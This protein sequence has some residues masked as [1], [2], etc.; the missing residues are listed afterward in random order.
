MLFR[1]RLEEAIK[2]DPVNEP[3]YFYLRLVM[4]SQF[5]IESKKREKTYGDRVVQ[6]TKK[7]NEGTRTD[8]PMPNQ[9]FRTNSNRPFLTH[10][11]LGAQR[12]NKKLDDI[13]FPEVNFPGLTLTEV[14]KTLDADTKK[15]DPEKKGLNYLINNVITDYISANAAGF[16]NLRIDST[17]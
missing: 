4:E 7:W 8:L 3:A 5:D 10:T 17:R 6:V 16:G 1:S 2:K 12:I 13:I 9:Y 11:S 14:V 15:H